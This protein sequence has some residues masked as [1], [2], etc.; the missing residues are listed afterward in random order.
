MTTEPETVPVF[1]GVSF[2]THFTSISIIGKDGKTETIANEDGFRNIPS[3]V[4]FTN[5]DQLTGS[6]A[7]VQAIRNP[8]NTILNFKHLL[9]KS[10]S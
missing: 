10:Y 8:K 2:G 3:I 9:S 4:S 7:L 6:Q 5:H 1:I